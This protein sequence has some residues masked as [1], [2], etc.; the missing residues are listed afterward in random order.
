M[1]YSIGELAKK[2]KIA[3][4]ALRYYEKEGLLLGVRRKASGVREFE[5]K[6]CLVLLL[7]DCLKQS[8]MSIKEI[9]NFIELSRG[10]CETL[11][12]RAQILDGLEVKFKAEIKRQKQALKQ[13]EYENWMYRQAAKL[14]SIEAVERLPSSAVPKKLRKVK[15]K[16]D[17]I[18]GSEEFF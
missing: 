7:I 4:S 1:S 10:G 14:G 2:F 16:I 8:G 17:K 11:Q 3:P 5:S 9:S 15:K 12:E 6:D 18:C 13:L